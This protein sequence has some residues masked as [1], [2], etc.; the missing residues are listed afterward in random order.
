MMVEDTETAL[1]WRGGEGVRMTL[2]SQTEGFLALFRVI[3]ERSR[4]GRPSSPLPFF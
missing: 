2:F 3:A 4:R 1:K